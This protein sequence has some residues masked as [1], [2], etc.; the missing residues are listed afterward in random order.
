[1][2]KLD[3][4]CKTQF[5]WMLEGI[6]VCDDCSKF[7]QNEQLLLASGHVRKY[8]YHFLFANI[9]DPDVL[10]IE[11]LW[12]CSEPSIALKIYQRMYKRTN[13]SDS[14][15]IFSFDLRRISIFFSLNT[16]DIVRI[17]GPST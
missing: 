16:L 11:S 7:L 3:K 12:G 17:H 1:M 4:N 6:D 8:S 14:G 15:S 10:N 13:E 9:N 5:K 2:N